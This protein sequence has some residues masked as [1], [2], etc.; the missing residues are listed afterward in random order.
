MADILI[1]NVIKMPKS[2]ITGKLPD[3]EYCPLFGDCSKTSGKTERP[4]D[5]PLLEL[6]PHGRLI[7]AHFD[8]AEFKKRYKDAYGDD[9]YLYNAFSI[10]NDMVVNAP[11]VL[12]ASR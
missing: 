3:Y 11:T 4:S 8:Y 2:C 10:F 12:E 6:P 7:E 5:C 9:F 1:K